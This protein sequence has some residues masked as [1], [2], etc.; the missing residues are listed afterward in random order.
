MKDRKKTLY[1]LTVR[2]AKEP[3]E[4]NTCREANKK[5]LHDKQNRIIET[6]GTQNAARNSTH[7]RRSAKGRALETNRRRELTKPHKPN[8]AGQ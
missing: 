8:P 4:R 5:R 3:T 7:V 2:I 1:D 6:I